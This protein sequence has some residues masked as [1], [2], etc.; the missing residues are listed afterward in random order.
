MEGLAVIAIFIILIVR[1]IKKHKASIKASQE[2]YRPED[3]GVPTE[4]KKTPTQ[5]WMEGERPPV[6]QRID[7]D[8]MQH[9]HVEHVPTQAQGFG[10]EGDRQ[11]YN[12]REVS[13][14]TVGHTEE[15]EP[16]IKLPELN[17]EN[18]ASA[19]IMSEILGKPKALRR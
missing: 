6:Q 17:R 4:P 15:A 14:E 10:G 11:R 5:Q 16:S 2:K 13:C 7:L 8:R 12:T 18:L 9:R 19:F 3:F 1:T